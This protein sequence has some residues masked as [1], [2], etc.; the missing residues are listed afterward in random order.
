[1]KHFNG[2]RG[3]AELEKIFNIILLKS[4]T[5]GTEGRE[6]EVCETLSVKNKS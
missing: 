3:K 5:E 2:D 6:T 4:R 1:M